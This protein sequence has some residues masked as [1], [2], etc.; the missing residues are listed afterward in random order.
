MKKP[1]KAVLISAL[2]YPGLGHFLFRHY[3]VGT[4]IISSFSIP[5][6]LLIGDI[7][8]TTEQVISQ[9]QRGEIP[10]EVSAI[11]NAILMASGSSMQTLSLYTYVMIIAWLIGILDIYRVTRKIQK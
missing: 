11:S 7:A 8:V 4:I 10:L 6:F 2:I 9:V 1:L 3:I 5:L